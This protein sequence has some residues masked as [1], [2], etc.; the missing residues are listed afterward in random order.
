MAP[1][2]VACWQEGDLTV[3]DSTAREVVP[4]DLGLDV[5]WGFD[6]GDPGDLENDGDANASIAAALKEGDEADE[7][8]WCLLFARS[9]E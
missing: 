4:I 3:E 7:S 5:R 8:P 2:L 6:L 9:R 1:A